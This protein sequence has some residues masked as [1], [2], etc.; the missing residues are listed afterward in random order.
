LFLTN[1]TL[2]NSDERGGSAYI[3]GFKED[4]GERSGAELS[5]MGEPSDK[6]ASKFSVVLY[7]GKNNE[8]I[9]DKFGGLS[10]S[11]YYHLNQKYINPYF[12]I[13]LFLGRT[14]NCTEEEEE[15]GDCLED[16]A[17]ITYPEVG[18]LVKLGELHIYP[19]VRRY[20]F[21]KENTYGFNLKLGI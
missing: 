7:S 19:F 6:M 3:G 13:G 2:A 5:F 11:Y 4:G 12:G 21:G 9:E 8:E 15:E 16:Y 10:L 20:D 1:I 18:I 17:A 14:F